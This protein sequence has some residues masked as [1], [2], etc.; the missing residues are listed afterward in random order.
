MSN[1]IGI[2][3]ISE[4]ILYA[5]G[6]GTD[7]SMYDYGWI[8]DSNSGRVVWDM[9]YRRTRYAGGARKN[10]LIDDTI[11]LPKG[12][13]EVFYESDDSHSFND[14]NDTPPWDLM[15]WGISVY[16]IQER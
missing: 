12:E 6:E 4:E 2:T 11:S 8:E 7:G 16:L 3:F 10:R 1:K 15:N 9:S 13:Y 5:L 14:W